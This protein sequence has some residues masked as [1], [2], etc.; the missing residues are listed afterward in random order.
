MYNIVNIITAFI[1]I[2]NA[3]DDDREKTEIFR[4]GSGYPA[5]C[6]FYSGIFYGNESPE[7]FLSLMS[8]GKPESNSRVKWN[9][10]THTHTHTHAHNGPLHNLLNTR[11]LRIDRDFFFHLLRSGLTKV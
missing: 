8:T 2:V 3:K 1:P 11:D 7:S 4:I 5:V 10:E 6:V 9:F